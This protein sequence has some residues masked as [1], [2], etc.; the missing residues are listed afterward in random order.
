MPKVK[1][2]KSVIAKS[3]EG[4]IQVTF[5]IPFE[6]I[7]KTKNLVAQELG[8]GIQIPGFRKGKAPLS[9][10]LNHISK[11]TL[12][13]KTLSKLL[14]ELYS[15]I[16]DK[17]KLKPIVLPKFEVIKANDNEDWEIRAT[18][19]ELPEFDL[20]D[21]K[22]QVQGALR[23]KSLWTPGKTEAKSPNKPLTREEKEQEV[24]KTLLSS[25][26]ISI[27]K[28]LIDNEV[29]SR[30]AKFL[31]RLERLG[32]SLESYL[33]S[34]GKTA[35][36]IREEYERQAREAISLDFILTKISKIEEEE[37]IIIC[38]TPRAIDIHNKF[39]AIETLLGRLFFVSALFCLRRKILL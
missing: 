5:T 9:K 3:D 6:K 20:N 19:C 37:L 4:T 24:I 30:L 1:S 13:E 38:I 23:A 25:I 12:L 8:K 33:S 10:L 29:D 26:K 11:N 39:I 15:E 34:V 32:L 31:Q 22:S 27:P 17:E 18:T 21:Y 28:I 16:I 7:K 35:K 14:P 2:A 36:T